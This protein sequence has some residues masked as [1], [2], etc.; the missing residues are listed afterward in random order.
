MNS[1]DSFLDRTTMYRLVLI[2]LASLAAVS[3]LCAFFGY[4]PYTAIDLSL[5]LVILLFSAYAANAVCALFMKASPTSESAFITALILFF[6]FAPLQSAGDA[7]TLMIAAA[8]AMLSKYLFAFGKKHIF[9]PAAFAAFALSIAGSSMVV[10][11]VAAPVLLPF[12]LVI[13]F[14]IMRKMRRFDVFSIFAITTL[15]VFLVRTTLSNIP[16]GTAAIGFFSAI[17]VIFFGTVMLCEPQ[18]TP[19]GRD[20]RRLYAGLVGILFSLSYP[21]AFR[22][23]MLSATPELALLIGNLYAFAVGMRRR[24][25]LTLHKVEQQSREIYEYLFVPDRSFAFVPGQYMEWTIPHVSADKRGI[26]RYFTIASP[27]SD[28]FVRLGVRI[29]GGSSTF[30]SAL[31]SLTKGD[32][33]TATRV[34]GEFTLPHDPNQPIAAIAGGIGI[35]PFMSM[36]R[37]LAHDRMR[38]DIVLMYVA[39][40]PLNLA[41]EEEIESFKI[42]IGLRVIYMPTDFMELAGWSGPSGY[43]TEEAI[44]KDIPDFN[45]RKWYLSGPTSMVQYYEYLVRSLG[46]SRTAIKTDSFPGFK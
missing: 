24:T 30:K 16:I 43:I 40:S 20:E 29:P 31:R 17:P 9:N 6:I 22:Y 18:T 5:S 21:F 27:P 11:W 39:S 46:V 34:A 4:L 8:V 1:L 23:G 26:R 28:P 32:R 41:Y 14:I 15:I 3:I 7:L 44:K 10:W 36:F 33:I 35:T 45:D 25:E 37:Q 38:R 12:I 2:G 19:A 42:S 13:G